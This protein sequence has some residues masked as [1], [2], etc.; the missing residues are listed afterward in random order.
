MMM[1]FVMPTAEGRNDERLTIRLTKVTCMLKLLRLRLSIHAI[2]G[3]PGGPK[4][5]KLELERNQEL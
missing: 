1:I 4:L 5:I 3:L 2:A